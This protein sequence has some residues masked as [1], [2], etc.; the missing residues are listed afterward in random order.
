MID[1]IAILL[2]LALGW[3]Q[4]RHEKHLRDLEARLQGEHVLPP[5]I[6]SQTL[7]SASQEL[8]DPIVDLEDAIGN[9]DALKNIIENHTITPDGIISN[10]TL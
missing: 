10:D 8:E 3:Q 1:Y 7:P 4:W 6:N 9:P 5:A 2:L